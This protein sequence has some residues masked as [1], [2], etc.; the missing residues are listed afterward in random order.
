MSA[1]Y[2]PSRS[3]ERPRFYIWVAIS[4]VLLVFVATRLL[5][6]GKETI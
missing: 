3:I 5:Y 1:G 6:I 2:V 4:F